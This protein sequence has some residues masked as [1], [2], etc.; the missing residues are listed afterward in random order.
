MKKITITNA[1]VIPFYKRNPNDQDEILR[2]VKPQEGGNF[3]SHIVNFNVE[4][5]ATDNAESKAKLF[6]R[7]TIYAKS[8]DHVANV[9]SV[10][11]N[12][13]ILELEGYETRSKGKNDDKYYTNIVVN[14]V[15]PISAGIEVDQDYAQQPSAQP[16]T[17]IP[18]DDDLPF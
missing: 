10:I 5:K 9:E 4:T 1:T 13:A 3:K 12:G 2:I 6:E 18:A 17:N 15:T 16:E 8:N 11:K 7:C 14:T